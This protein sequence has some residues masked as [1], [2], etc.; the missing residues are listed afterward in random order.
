MGWVIGNTYHTT[1]T[2]V[3]SVA[4]GDL[5]VVMAACSSGNSNEP[6]FSGDTV[7]NTYTK[8]GSVDSDRP[9][10]ITVFWAISVGTNASNT[11]NTSFTNEEQI[12]IALFT[13]TGGSLPGS[14]VDTF[15][16]AVTNA[17]L[18]LTTS[19]ANTLL[20][21][22]SDSSNTTSPGTGFTQIFQ[23]ANTMR[24]MSEYNLSANSAGSNTVSITTSIPRG[25]IGVAFKPPSTGGGPF[26]HFQRRAKELTGGLSSIGM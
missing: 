2:P 23:D 6:T 19:V 12:H 25:L 10:R 15:G 3:I 24:L 22:A 9:A 16:T 7:G 14:P 11:I 5:I 26:P 4:A 20:I 17:S 1:G 21:G 8:I 13:H 18:S